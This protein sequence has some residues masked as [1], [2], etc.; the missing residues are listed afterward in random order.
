MSSTVKPD[1]KK[2]KPSP[3]PNTAKKNSRN[4]I[5][6]PPKESTTTS[7]A[8]SAST[9]HTNK[10]TSDDEVKKVEASTDG[11]SDADYITK[12]KNVKVYDESDEDIGQKPKSKR[13]FFKDEVDESDKEVG[14]VNNSNENV[15]TT[16][17]IQSYDES[18]HEYEDLGV[19]Y[20]DSEDGD[21]YG[22]EKDG[23]VVAG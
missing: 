7:F 6:V 23:F 3:T 16:S 18:D 17:D 1:S 19:S 4:D 10:S 9:T 21:Y 11:N 14:Y 13:F 20:G 8:S 15:S 22:Y 12:K 5:T 2:R